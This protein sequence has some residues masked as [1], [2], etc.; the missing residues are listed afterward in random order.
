MVI[1]EGLSKGTALEMISGENI[2]WDEVAN[3]LRALA[4]D[5][6]DDAFVGALAHLDM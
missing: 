6:R 1:F 3:V 5:W 2:V 4:Y